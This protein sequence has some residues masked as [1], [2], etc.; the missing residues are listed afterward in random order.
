MI[1]FLESEEDEDEYR[2]RTRQNKKL[3]TLEHLMD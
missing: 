1:D 3:P 2:P